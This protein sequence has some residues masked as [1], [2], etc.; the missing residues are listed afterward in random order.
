M[1]DSNYDFSGSSIPVGIAI[2][3]QRQPEGL[4]L[5]PWKPLASPTA[6]GASP[7]HPTLGSLGGPSGTS[8][9][10]S[11]LPPPPPSLHQSLHGPWGLPP[12][13]LP[14]PAGPIPMGY[15]LA[16]DPLTGQILLIPTGM[17]FKR[18]FLLNNLRK[19]AACDRVEQR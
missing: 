5:Q 3:R 15:Q 7:L 13:H 11:A 9:G 19:C 1:I 6:G 14:S 12:H 17:N 16:K 4:S 18:L 2:G 10:A 8:A